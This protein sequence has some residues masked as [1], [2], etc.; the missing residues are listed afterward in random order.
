[1]NNAINLNVNH[2]LPYYNLATLLQKEGRFEERL[3]I[4]T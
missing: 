3:K 2:Y 4:N 1:M